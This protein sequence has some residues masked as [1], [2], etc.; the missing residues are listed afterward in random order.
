MKNLNLRTHS[1]D[2]EWNDSTRWHSIFSSAQ[3]PH[4]SQYMF[5]TSSLF[6]AHYIDTVLSIIDSMI[7]LTTQNKF[8]LYFLEMS[9]FG[10]QASLSCQNTNMRFTNPVTQHIKVL[11]CTTVLCTVWRNSFLLIFITMRPFHPPTDFKT[12][13]HSDS[14]SQ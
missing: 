1:S 6:L 10:I 9:S 7:S 14:K 11:L 2:H 4:P 13:P 12:L 3:M 5:F 8:L